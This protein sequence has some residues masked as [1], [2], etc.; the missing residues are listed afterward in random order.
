MAEAIFKGVSGRLH[1]FS[2]F[3]PNVPDAGQPRRL[4]VRAP[5]QW[6]RFGPRS[7]SRA[8][9]TWPSVWAVTNHGMRRAVWARRIS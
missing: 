1:R 8:P 4:C 7:F 9:P 2:A 5:G 3:A 6:R